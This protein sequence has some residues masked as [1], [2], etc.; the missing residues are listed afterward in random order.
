MR[1]RPGGRF[2]DRPD[3]P[4]IEGK[5]ADTYAQNIPMLM[6]FRLNGK[7]E[8]QGWRDCPFWWPVLYMPKHMQT[9]VFASDV[10]ES[11]PPLEVEN[12]A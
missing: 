4:H 11:S 3:T 1:K 6:L 9:V 12:A 10:E 2:Q 5:I 8:E 7:K